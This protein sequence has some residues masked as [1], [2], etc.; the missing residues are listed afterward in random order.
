MNKKLSIMV[1]SSIILSTATAFGSAMGGYDP[2]LV[3]S[4]YMKDIRSFDL[5]KEN[6]KR[7]QQIETPQVQQKIA[8]GNLASVSF[9]NNRAFSEKTLQGIVNEY[10][11]QPLTPT[12]LMDMRKK[13]MKFYQSNGYYSA[14]AIVENENMRDGT[15]TFRIQ[16]GTK[17]S[18]QIDGGYYD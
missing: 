8:A 6:A 12:I 16:E 9:L 15:V 17:D 4:N 2:G 14:V 7:V 11:G 5:R 1:L 18:I 10:I 3:N 13:I